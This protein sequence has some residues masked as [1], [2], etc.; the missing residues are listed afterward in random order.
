MT[1]RP[2]DMRIYWIGRLICRVRRALLYWFWPSYI[3]RSIANRKGKCNICALCCW[4]RCEYLRP[5]GKC[6][7]VLE[8]E[9]YPDGHGK[10]CEDFPIDNFEKTMYGVQ[11]YCGYWWGTGASNIREKKKRYSLGAHMRKVQ[12]GDTGLP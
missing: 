2:K 10:R 7:A 9:K 3:E 6:R 4:D 8:P 1:P 5:D 12:E 11:K